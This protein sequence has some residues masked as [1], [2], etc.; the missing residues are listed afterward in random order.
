MGSWAAL[1][2]LLPTGQEMILLRPGEA[3]PGMLCP[4]LGSSGQE[5]H[6][7]PGVGLEGY[8]GDEGTGLSSY[9]DRLRELGLF[10]LDMGQLRGTPSMSVS[11]FRDVSE[12]GA[13]SAQ[14]CPATGQ[15]ATDRN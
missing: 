12:D 9:K 4:V 5:G 3:S 15:E 7:A 11:V 1:G 6:G 8:K 14:G 13:G 2:R 10:S